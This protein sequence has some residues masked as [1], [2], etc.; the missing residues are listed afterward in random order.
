MITSL[1]G[2]EGNI[3]PVH[4]EP[5]IGEVERLI[6]DTTKAKNFVGWEPKYNLE[7]GLKAFIQ[8]YKNYGLEERIKLG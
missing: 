3:E 7:Q 1:S 5:R 2:K 6:A 4:V 8:W